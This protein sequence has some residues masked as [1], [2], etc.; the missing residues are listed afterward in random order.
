MEIAKAALR[1]L[2]VRFVPAL[3]S[4]QALHVDSPVTKSAQGCV[5]ALQSAIGGFQILDIMLEVVQSP[6]ARAQ[7]RQSTPWNAS[8]WKALEVGKGSEM[9]PVPQYHMM[10]CSCLTFC[11]VWVGRL[12]Q[13]CESVCVKP[14][15]DVSFL[16]VTLEIR[17]TGTAVPAF[18]VACNPSSHRPLP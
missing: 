12:C 6:V 11:T 9:F 8:D 7:V 18:S 3:D 13:I 16:H 14:L 1:L 15:P 10:C 4:E 17:V 2:L 5:V